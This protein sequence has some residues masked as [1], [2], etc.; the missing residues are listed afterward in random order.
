VEEKLDWYLVGLMEGSSSF[1]P[2]GMDG[3]ASQSQEV[4]YKGQIDCHR[5]PLLFHWEW[6]GAEDSPG[7]LSFFLLPEEAKVGVSVDLP[8]KAE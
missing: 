7:F 3:T 8:T 6:D 5:L 1:R 4:L 2:V